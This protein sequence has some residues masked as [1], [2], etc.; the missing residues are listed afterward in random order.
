MLLKRH[1]QNRLS[2]MKVFLLLKLEEVIGQL[3]IALKK[4]K[5]NP[6]WLQISITHFIAFPKD[7]RYIGE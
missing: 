2:N 1:R 5:R 3:D 7:S 6:Q 4:S